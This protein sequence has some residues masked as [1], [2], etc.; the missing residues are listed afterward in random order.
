MTPADR[1]RKER[2]KKASQGRVRKE[3]W[4]HK[5]DADKLKE[6]DRKMLKKR[7]LLEG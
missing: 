4:P 7:G 5:D 3:Y 1:K 2:E 6:Y